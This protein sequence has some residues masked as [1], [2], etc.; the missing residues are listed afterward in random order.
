MV[1]SPNSPGPGRG[2]SASA[3][4][5]A[6]ALVVF[7]LAAFNVA[8]WHVQMVPLGLAFMALGFLV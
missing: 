6:L 2:V 7:V 1:S 4:C 3:V 8:P 5:M